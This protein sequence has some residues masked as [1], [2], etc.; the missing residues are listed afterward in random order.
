MKLSPSEYWGIVRQDFHT[1]V[2]RSFY[3]LNPDTEFLPNWHIEEIANFG[4]GWKDW[5]T[6]A[7]YFI[8]I[9]GLNMEEACAKLRQYNLQGAKVE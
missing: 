3:E 2:E 4:V 7:K 1:F 5:G 6:L 9:H 8:A